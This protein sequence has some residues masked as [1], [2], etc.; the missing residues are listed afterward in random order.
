METLLLSAPLSIRASLREGWHLV[1][2]TKLPVL[3]TLLPMLVVSVIAFSILGF[4][5]FS[6]SANHVV[7]GVYT[8]IS[9][10]IHGL[11]TLGFISGLL[12]I[13]LKRARHEPVSYFQGLKYFSQLPKIAVVGYLVNWIIMIP[14]IVFI[15]ASVYMISK[16]HL[17]HHV[18]EIL[19]VLVS[20][21]IIFGL[22][23]LFL[24][25]FQ[26]ALDKNYSIL[27]SI[28][29][30]AKAVKPYFWKIFSLLIILTAL[31]IVGACFAGIGLF[32][33]LPLTLN[34]MGLVYCKL[35]DK[36]I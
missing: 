19:L 18:A 29:R 4:F 27:A 10:L 14:T 23:T 6:N 33:T 5:D 7:A 34:T 36:G 8:V 13:G 3:L 24:F 26:L 11:I 1:R 30:S 2:G 32:W 20:L 22:D 15:M 12:M 31:N 21:F 28:S 16:F 25:S 17:N 9:P 35:I